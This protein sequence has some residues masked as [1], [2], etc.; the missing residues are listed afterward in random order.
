[1]KPAA[2]VYLLAGSANL[3]PR[4]CRGLAAPGL[5]YL[6]LG[7]FSIEVSLQTASNRGV[8]ISSPPV[9]EK[10]PSEIPRAGCVEP[11]DDTTSR[12]RGSLRSVRFPLQAAS[13]YD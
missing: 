6:Y 3:P 8:V 7:C 2:P 4:N 10:S 13:G 5:A 12:L 9:G 11:Q 1:M